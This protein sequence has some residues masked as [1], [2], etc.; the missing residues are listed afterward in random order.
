M[1]HAIET[2]DPLNVL[3]NAARYTDPNGEIQIETHAEG[4]QA[5]TRSGGGGELV[6]GL[7]LQ[8]RHGKR[9]HYDCRN[10]RRLSL[11]ASTSEFLMTTRNTSLDASFIEKQRQYLTQLQRSLRTA[12]DAGTAEEGEINNSSQESEE[13]EDDAQ[14]L[15]A[16]ELEGN[17]IFRD[18]E[19]LERV[20]RAL[21]KIAEGTYGMSDVSGQAIPRARLEAVPEATCTLAEEKT[22]E[23]R[24]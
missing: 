7:G 6:S 1:S 13:A 5:V 10:Y 18:I 4:E 20:E 24:N 16:L 12:V 3:A 15:A 11:R 22:A 2:I 9:H 19:R 14:R 17:L 8:L 23:R 21:H